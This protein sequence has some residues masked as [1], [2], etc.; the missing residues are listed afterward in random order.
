MSPVYRTLG[1]VA[2][3]VELGFCCLPPQGVVR[4]SGRGYDGVLIGMSGWG[5]EPSEIKG[6]ESTIEVIIPFP[7]PKCNLACPLL[8]ESRRLYTV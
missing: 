2:E 8:L 5:A 1:F 7:V 6:L 4:F 3:D